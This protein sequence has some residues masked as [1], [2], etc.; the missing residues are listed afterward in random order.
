MADIKRYIGI[1][2]SKDSL[3]ISPFDKGAPSVLNQSK[4]I[5]RLIARLQKI[6]NAIICCEATGGYEKL[7]V[8]ECLAK[9]QPIA[10]VNARQVRDFA[11]SK[12]ILAKTDKIDAAVLG[13]YGTQNTPEPMKRKPL[14][15]NRLNDL[16]R[17]RDDL[18]KMSKQE[19]CR[20]QPTQ[21]KEIG[22]MIVKHIKI[23][24]KMIVEIEKEVDKIMEA[25]N[26]FKE[27]FDDFT[28]VK[29]IGRQT[30]VYLVGFVPELGHVTGNQAAALVGLAPFCNDSGKF[31]GQRSIRGGRSEVR[32]VL[33]MSALSAKT[34]NPILREFYNRLIAA[35]KPPKLALTAVMRKIVVLANKICADPEFK[36]T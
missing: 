22:K 27:K 19:K 14:W 34:H 9:E 15:L 28:E 35:G 13:D 6:D 36:L 10:L 16:L 11:K 3:E 31:K 25:E 18:V 5:K 20:L 8:T 26:V 24:E 7:L 33:Y 12:G 32:R 17:R 21:S 23:L 29:G 2:I 30:A 1:D 4:D